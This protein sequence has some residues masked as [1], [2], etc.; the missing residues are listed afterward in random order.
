MEI[1]KNNRNGS[2]R[3]KDL[4]LLKRRWFPLWKLDGYVLRE[5]LIKYSILLLVF[6]ILF[7]LSDI[8]RDI[9]DFFE[10]EASW[11]DILLYLM[12]RLPGNIRFILP[13]SMLLG[14]MWT[15]AAF[16][17]NMEVTAM[18]ASG[19]SLIRCGFS[20][21]IV[22]LLVSLVN[23]YFNEALIPWSSAAAERLYEQKA[24][25][26]R[27]SHSL[28]SYNSSDGSRRWL[29]QVFTGGN[30]YNNVTLKTVWNEQYIQK[31]IGTPG[32]EIYYDRIRKIFGRAG[33]EKLL[34]LPLAEQK[35]ELSKLLTDRKMDFFIDEA[36]YDFAK[37]EW[38]VL[39]G[40]FVSYDR[41]TESMFSSSTGTSEMHAD[42]VLDEPLILPEDIV[43]ETPDDIANS[44]KAKDDLSTPVIYQ[45]L[46]NNPGMPERAKCI[47]LTVFFYR[48]AFPWASFL[49][50]FLG[51]PLAT[52]NE[53][54]GSMLAITSAI[55]LIIIYIVVAQIF[56]MLGKSGA[57][58]PVV[59]GFAPTVCFIA[60]GALRILTDRN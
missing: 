29:F 38:K 17:K 40:K 54:T 49:A 48:I 16:G 26:R 42:I 19:V 57:V 33:S 60:A 24:Q 35:R 28:L 2:V 58:N 15:M 4:K 9:S 34:A 43:R 39:K 22:G 6:V 31:L 25:G 10:A 50:V 36:E 1:D 18:R 21:F 46:K 41:S 23:V 3:Y 20:I 12:L 44:V 13:I 52:K 56:L 51:I 53:R 8:Y 45:V 37:K 27:F 5:F 59:A 14:C 32:G 47:Y 30:K 7:I 11:R 55:A